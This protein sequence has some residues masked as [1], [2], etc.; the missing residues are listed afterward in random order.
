MPV[1]ASS[2]INKG[3]IKAEIR[4]GVTKINVET[5]IRQK[6]EKGLN[7][8]DVPFAQRLVREEVKNLIDNYFEIRGNALEL[9]SLLSNDSNLQ[10]S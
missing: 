2:E 3:N 10:P 4:N 1:L 6:Y 7:A 9:A 5:A 8:K